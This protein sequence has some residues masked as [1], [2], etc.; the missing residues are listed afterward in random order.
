MF[1][2]IIPWLLMLPLYGMVAM[3]I[4]W[5]LWSTF[6]T[7]ISINSYKLEPD[8]YHGIKKVEHKIDEDGA[9][10]LHPG[11]LITIVTES[12]RNASCVLSITRVLENKH[13]DF[14]YY[15]NTST[16]KITPNNHVVLYNHIQIPPNVISGDYW[17]YS[18][19]SIICNPMGYLFPIEIST[20]HIDVKIEQSNDIDLQNSRVI[21]DFSS[22]SSKQSAASKSAASSSR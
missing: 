5:L 15:I 12:K 18:K 7:P 16:R 6:S 8:I 3:M 1:K 14:S 21:Q 20:K 4:Y 11:D 13:S 17:L 2:R 19:L 22:D 9:I 10:I